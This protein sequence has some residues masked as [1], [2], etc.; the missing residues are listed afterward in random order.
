[1]TLKSGEVG[2]YYS[3]FFGGTVTSS[4]LGE[5]FHYKLPWDK[6]Y[7]YDTRYQSRD[8][9][10]T[11]LSK[12][13]LSVDIS[14]SAVWRVDKE[15]IGTLHKLIGEDYAEKIIIPA[16]ESAVRSTV[17][18]YEQSELYDGD[19]LVLQDQIENLLVTT[20]QDFPFEITAFL[21]KK[22][23]LPEKMEASIEDKF[24]SEQKV[25]EQKY[26]VLEAFEAYKRSYIEAESTRTTQQIINKG[27][28]ENYLRYMG[29]K[30][31]LELAKSNNAKLVIIG[32][33]DGMPLLLNPDNLDESKS[34]EKGT[35]A[36]TD[37]T[38]YADTA[39][40][41]RA[42]LD[43]MADMINKYNDLLDLFLKEHPEISD[44]IPSD[45]LDQMGSITA[46]GSGATSDGSGKK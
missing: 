6:I 4:F 21:I 33:K 34:L 43:E 1:V 29:I 24:V 25:L 19:P 15:Q 39:D 3:R 37:D 10:V 42:K 14:L 30:A 20:F 27:L 17:G 8:F 7:V 22:I 13:G 2:V 45:L 26:K 5:G 44:S 40:E 38:S 28:T 11:A 12:G 18:S 46:D 35:E 23:D 16:V 36:A 41:Y 31:T 32:D 9:T